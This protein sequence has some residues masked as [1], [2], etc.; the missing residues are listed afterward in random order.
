[1]FHQQALDGLRLSAW[2]QDIFGRNFPCEDIGQRSDATLDDVGNGTQI[3]N[4]VD[5]S[6]ER[7]RRGRGVLA[8]RQRTHMV[9]I[10]GNQPMPAQHVD[11]GIQQGVVLRQ[12]QAPLGDGGTRDPHAEFGDR[13][14][15]GQGCEKLL[16][17][18]GV[19]LVETGKRGWGNRRLRRLR[20]RD[21]RRYGQV[22]L[23]VDPMS[24]AVEW[25][26][27]Q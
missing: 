10:Q 23:Q 8:V 13:A 24:A 11:T 1:M 15:A 14:G 7:S 6:A 19:Q 27:R 22:R 12:P 9:T 3:R 2:E 16:R 26:Q 4:G 20:W 17:G 25:V 18:V 21:R 5:R